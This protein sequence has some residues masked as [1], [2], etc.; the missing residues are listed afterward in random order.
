MAHPHAGRLTKPLPIVTTREAAFMHDVSP[1]TI[2]SW[3]RRGWLTPVC[4]IDGAHRFRLEDVDRAEKEVRD[5]DLS[6]RSTRR[7]Y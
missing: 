1:T 2:R 6:G 3:V 4:R 5:R 7:A